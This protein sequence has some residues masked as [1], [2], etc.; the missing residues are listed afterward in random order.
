M[1]ARKFILR[2]ADIRDR[3]VAFVASLPVGDERPFELVARPYK[4]SRTLAQNATFHFWMGTIANAY[5]ESHGERIAPDVWKE[6]FK[7]RFLGEDS[8]EIM[9]KIVTTT[10]S[11]AGLKIDEFCTLLDAVDRWAVEHLQVFLPRGA[12]YDEAMGRTT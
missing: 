4:K 9:G 11:T 5:E 10:R 8:V 2:N 7:R 1:T 3:A 6:F 12:D